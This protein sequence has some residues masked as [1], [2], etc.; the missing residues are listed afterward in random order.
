MKYFLIAS[1]ALVP[2]WSAVAAQDSDDI[3]V[4]VGLGAQLQPSFIGSKGT[5]VAPL[6]HL[7]IAHG[8]KE[9]RFG[10]PDDSP[11]IAVISG[12]GFSFGPAAN[13]QA[14]R[15]NSDAGARV[16]SVP[17]T[18]E[19]GAFAQYEATDSF[20][21]R[22]ELLK[23]INGHNGVLGSIGADKIWRDGDRYVFSIGPRVL[24]SDARFQ[25]AYFGVSAA[26]SVASGL[27]TY[28]PG[29][30]VYAVAVASGLS[31]QFQRR[32]GLFGF[33]R[34]ERLVGDAARSPII[35]QL[36]SRNQLSAGIGLNYTFTIRR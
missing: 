32:W 26:A 14:R 10:A 20:R 17:R 33:A 34:Y 1:A 16:G 25:R 23:G 13:L 3:R 31:Y 19:V 9:F 4:R 28:R 29:S 15:E 27:P 8:T 22:A 30:G 12:D 21:V 7:N 35:R 11:G 6:F 5:D 18:I 2:A 24:F 36:G